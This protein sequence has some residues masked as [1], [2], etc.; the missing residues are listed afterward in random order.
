MDCLFLNTHQTVSVSHLIQ[1]E[2]Y[3]S[4]LELVLISEQKFCVKINTSDR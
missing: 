2:V 1:V 3:H 4:I